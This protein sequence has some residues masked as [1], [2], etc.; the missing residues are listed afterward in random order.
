MLNLPQLHYFYLTA[1]AR[2]FARAS[3]QANITQPALSN[4][5]KTLE[6]RLG[7]DLF[8]REE[9]PIRLTARGRS[10]F[11]HVERLLF[12]AQNVDTSA[13]TL[14]DGDQGHIRL[15]MTAVFAASFGGEATSRWLADFPK[16]TLDVMVR[17]S[18]V[19]LKKVLDED[20]DL[21]VGTAQ[22]LQ[23]AAG[24]LDIFELPTQQ[25]R[26]LVRTGHPLLEKQQIEKADLERYGCVASH[27]SPSVLGQLAQSFGFDTRE[28][29]P[30][31]VN[32]ES[33]DLLCDLTARSDYLLLSTRACTR[34][35]VALGRI[36]DLGVDLGIDAYWQIACRRGRLLHPKAQDLIA[37]ITQV[38]SEAAQVRIV[39]KS[40]G[41]SGG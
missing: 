18:P 26:A 17:P 38:C 25:G 11:D 6:E 2:S 41:K 30:V 7:F 12:L 29:L 34:H 5:I 3:E 14:R 22:E 27:F 31:R 8:D 16:M 21:I 35:A 9:R 37:L 23:G 4:A 36:C 10:F 40:E 28:D 32:S 1:K 15:G 24:D 39:D 33:I 13:K 19:L 20:L